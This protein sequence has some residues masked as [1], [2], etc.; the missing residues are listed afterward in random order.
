M[1]RH[2]ISGA[3]SRE[4]AVDFLGEP[5]AIAFYERMR[6]EIDSDS[7]IYNWCLNK[8]SQFS[9]ESI[10]DIADV[11]WYIFMEEHYLSRDPSFKQF[12]DEDPQIA[13]TIIRFMMSEPLE[14]DIIWIRHEIYELNLIEEYEMTVQEAH[15]ETQQVFN[16]QQYITNNDVPSDLELYGRKVF[17]IEFLEDTL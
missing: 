17:D 16:Y 14:Y 6:E 11:F 4:D 5:Q 2:G 7:D 1:R 13:A 3:L 8:I 15:E 9:G 10:T 12:L